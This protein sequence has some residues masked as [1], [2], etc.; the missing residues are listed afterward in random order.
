MENAQ[1]SKSSVALLSVLSNS[2]LVLLKLIIGV[3]I[4]S[5]SVIS[6]AI[7]SGVDLVAALI[8]LFA[9][10]TSEKPADEEHPFGHGKIENVS[11]TI[12]ALLIFVAALWI[13]FEAIQKLLHPKPMEDTSWGVGIML[14]SA[15]ANLF[16]SHML[17]KVGNKTDS[18]ALKADAW[19]LRTDVYTSGGVMLGLALS[20]IGARVL[21]GKNLQW[22]DPVAA[23]GVALLIV[24]A[25]Y[26]LTLESGKDLLDVSLPAEEETWIHDYVT[27]LRDDVRGFHHLRTRKAGSQRFI[28]F[29]LLVNAE[30]SV[31]QSH[32]LNDDIVATIK[33]RFPA[34]NVTIHIEPC[35]ATCKPDC[36]AGCLL[37]EKERQEV[38]RRYLK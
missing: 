27:G 35:D 4:G 38:R 16:V 5:V 29:H 31:E 21:P 20:W 34:S 30:M 25:A 19:H 3:F 14:V 11:G 22:L 17:F 18:A 12:E 8:A 36:I 10:R 23:I 15:L 7:H 26:H 2:T 9:V 13:I 24:R 37:S 1:R 28:Q 6:E 33:R 32:Q